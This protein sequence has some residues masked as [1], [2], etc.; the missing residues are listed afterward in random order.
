MFIFPLRNGQVQFQTEAGDQPLRL[1]VRQDVKSRAG[2]KILGRSIMVFNFEP[3]GAVT[4][5]NSPTGASAHGREA[6]ASNDER[7]ASATVVAAAGGGAADAAAA[8]VAAG[9]AGGGAGGGGID[10]DSIA[11]V[12]DCVVFVHDRV[13]CELTTVGR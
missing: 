8:A 10:G 3:A 5:S 4:S 13:S 11:G 6:P 2:L 7:T 12:S 1:T 9:G